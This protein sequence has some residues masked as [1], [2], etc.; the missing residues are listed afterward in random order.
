MAIEFMYGG[1]VHILKHNGM[2]NPF[3]MTTVFV[4]LVAVTIQYVVRFI[5][6]EFNNALLNSSSAEWTAMKNK[7][8]LNVS[9][10]NFVD[11]LN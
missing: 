8:S 6:E 11:L 10:L 2:R 1:D 5:K 7:I 4:L 9:N 3:E